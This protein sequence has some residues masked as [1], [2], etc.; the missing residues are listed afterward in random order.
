MGVNQTGEPLQETEVLV[1]LNDVI[2]EDADP[3]TMKR[4]VSKNTLLIESAFNESASVSLLA[5]A[6]QEKTV[7]IPHDI[8]NVEAMEAASIEIK[9]IIREKGFISAKE[10]AEIIQQKMRVLEVLWSHFPGAKSSEAVLEGFKKVVEKR[11]YTAK[12]TLFAQVKCRS[13]S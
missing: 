8:T 4:V 6:E 3:V 11:G 1:Q 9:Q 2:N 13:E 5:E 10:S 12:N 7:D